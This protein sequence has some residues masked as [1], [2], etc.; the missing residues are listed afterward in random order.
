MRIY[1]GWDEKAPLLAE[2]SGDNPP[3][4]E[5]VAFNSSV[6]YLVFRSDSR[7]QSQGFHGSFLIQREYVVD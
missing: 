5:G 4:P 3:P 6:A 1:S 2:F 7:G